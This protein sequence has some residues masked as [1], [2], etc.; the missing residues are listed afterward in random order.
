MATGVQTGIVPTRAKV[1]EQLLE[2]LQHVPTLCNL[3]AEELASFPTLERW[4]LTEGATLIVPIGSM[5]A[6]WALLE[7]EI[8]IWKL[9]GQAEVQISKQH[10]GESF[11]EVPLLLGHRVVTSRAVATLP[12]RLIRFAA[13][14][15]W[16]MMAVSP[17]TRELI[18]ADHARRYETYHA[19]ALH[20]EKLISLGTLAAGLMHELNNPGAAARRGASQLRE[21]IMRLQAISL[22]LTRA[23]LSQE[24]LACLGDLQEQVLAP[25]KP[26]ML[27]PL[28]QS[29][30]EDELASWLESVKVENSW[31]LAPALVGAGMAG[32][33]LACAESAFPAGILSDALN[34]IEALISSMQHVNTIEESIARVTDLVTAV[35]KYAYDDKNKQQMV[36]VRDSLLSTLTILNHKFRQKSLQVERSLP[37]SEIRISCMGTS[38][39]QVWTNLLDNAIDAAPENG[40]ISVRLWTENEWVCIAI[41]DNGPGIPKEHWD[42]IFEPFY[43][44]KDAGVGTGLGLDIAHRIVVGNFHGEIDFT[45]EPGATEFIVKLPMRHPGLQD[46]PGCKIA[47][48]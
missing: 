46:L 16:K 12:S 34:Y 1:D 5:G 25:Q 7:G 20:R 40:A 21:N 36:D 9:D 38:L 41:R 23:A 44:T 27:S 22:R 6:Y 13:A 48:N 15:F 37:A 42:H 31:R 45:T 4:D 18:L 17:A 19:M 10:A 30:R 26:S 2:E 8:T 14:D 28:E 29:D 24:Q 47:A 3:T 39:G 43:T 32:G 33:D 35:K 11:G